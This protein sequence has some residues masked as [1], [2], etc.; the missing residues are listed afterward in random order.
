MFCFPFSRLDLDPKKRHNSKEKKRKERIGYNIRKLWQLVPIEYHVSG[1]KEVR[2]RLKVHSHLRFIRR[3]LLRELF[4]PAIVKNG[5]ATFVVNCSHCPTVRPIKN[6]VHTAQRQTTTQIPIGFWAQ[7]ISLSICVGQWNTTSTTVVI[8]QT[9][10]SM[11]EKSRD[12]VS[13]L[14]K[15]LDKYLLGQGDQA[16]GK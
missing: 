2:M 8:F 6:T 3:K 11:L 5:Y 9:L 1:H 7:S 13:F 15:K 10:V 14:Q 4:S 16:L 12:Y